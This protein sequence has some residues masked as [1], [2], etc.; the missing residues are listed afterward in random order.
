[1]EMT[2]RVRPAAGDYTAP[3]AEYGPAYGASM[4]YGIVVVKVQRINGTLLLNAGLA[5]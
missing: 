1:M 4:S 2:E 5:K 3:L